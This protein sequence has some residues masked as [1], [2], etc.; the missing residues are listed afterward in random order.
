MASPLGHPRLHLA[1][2]TLQPRGAQLTLSGTRQIP[3]PSHPPRP[4]K[5]FSLQLGAEQGAPAG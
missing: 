4:V 1:R 3:C 2:R 5:V